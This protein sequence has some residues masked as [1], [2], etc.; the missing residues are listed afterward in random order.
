MTLAGLSA[1]RVGGIARHRDVPLRR[2]HDLDLHQLVARGFDVRS[3]AAADTLIGTNID[4]RLTDGP[5]A[6]LSHRHG[7]LLIL[8]HLAAGAHHRTMTGSTMHGVLLH[9]RQVVG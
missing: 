3:T 1:Q 6:P 2:S 9:G 7:A 4:D 8:E 5:A